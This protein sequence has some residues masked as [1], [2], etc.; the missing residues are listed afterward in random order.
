MVVERFGVSIERELLAKFDRLIK[1]RGYTNRSE[2]IR[3][4]IRDALLEEATAAEDA[5][6]FGTL[7]L[8]YDHDA[9]DV[10]EKLLHIQH[11]WHAY[12]VSTTHIHISKHLCMEI[13]ALRGKMTEMKKLAENLRAL[14]GVLYGKFVAVKG[15]V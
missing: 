1:A 3:D 8:V 9:G 11:R 12:I 4:L 14:K 7:T 5:E 2:A 15:E 6:G 13:L 10:V